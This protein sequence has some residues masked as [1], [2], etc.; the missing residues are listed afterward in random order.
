MD[1]FQNDKLQQKIWPNRPNGV[2]KKSLYTTPFDRMLCIVLYF[3]SESD[4]EG[5]IHKII[6]V[7]LKGIFIVNTIQA[8]MK[9]M[10]HQKWN[11]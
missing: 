10:R 3:E 8:E 5:R 1:P 11:P 2:T 7:N 4:S 9:P 6:L